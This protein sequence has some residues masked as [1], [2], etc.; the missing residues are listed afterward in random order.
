MTTWWIHDRKE[1][2]C[3]SI[4]TARAALVVAAQN[5]AVLPKGHFKARRRLSLGTI[6]M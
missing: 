1:Q 6:F 3:S 4:E 5:V 2:I